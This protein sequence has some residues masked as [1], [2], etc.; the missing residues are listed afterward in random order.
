MT[1][2]GAGAFGKKAKLI[3]A[4]QTFQQ[5]QLVLFGQRG[6]A[7]DKQRTR[8]TCQKPD[9]GPAIHLG[10]RDEGYPRRTV[11]RE[12]IQPRGMIGHQCPAVL[13]VLA[14]DL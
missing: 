4:I 12:N 1:A 10:F 14:H 11:E 6:A 13:H 5:S 3:T 7:L 8:D 9:N 2:I